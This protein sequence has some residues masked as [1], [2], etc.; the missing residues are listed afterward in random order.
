M[1]E[2]YKVVRICK[3]YLEIIKA[4]NVLSIIIFLFLFTQSYAREKGKPNIILFLTDDQGWTDTSLQMMEGRPESKSHYYQTPHLERL[5]QAGMIFSAGYSPAAICSPTRTSIQFGKTPARLHNTSHNRGAANCFEEI[6]LPKM[7]KEADSD[8][9]TAHFGKWGLH[10]KPERWGY[11]SS[12]GHTNNYHGDWIGRDDRRGTPDDDPKKIFSLT[13]KANDF[14]EEQVNNNHPFYLQI[15]HYALHVQHRALKET[16]EKYRKLPPGRRCLPA[17]YNTP[18]PGLNE[19]ILEYAAM[20]E[21]MDSSLGIILDKLEEM[22]IVDNTY[23]IYISDNG[24][25]FR[26]NDPLRGKKAQLWEGGIRVPFVIRGPG[27][28]AGVYCNEPVTGWDLYKTFA[29]IIGL[30]ERKL[31]DDL[32]GCSIKPLFTN[33]QTTLPRGPEGLIFHFPYDI[34][35]SAIRLGDYKLVLDWE[36]AAKHLYHIKDDLSEQNDLA[37]EMPDKTQEL[38]IRLAQYLKTVNAENPIDLQKERV[39]VFEELRQNIGQDLRKIMR[40]QDSDASDQWSR[41]NLRRGFIERTLK[42]SQESLEKL[43][44][45]VPKL[46]VF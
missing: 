38:F 22:G 13:K 45:N 32:D 6:A 5:A 23:F 46:A 11:D 41:M 12:S 25:S 39:E 44:K 19:W 28:K 17:D 40:S 16:I 30:D 14:I 9:M 2:D 18:P 21:N 8:Y 7:F 37:E 3:K 31:P 35:D 33:P 24:G 20:I 34:C 36:N 4:I 10:D 1:L 43:R 29:E 42:T 26:G 27:V 15:S